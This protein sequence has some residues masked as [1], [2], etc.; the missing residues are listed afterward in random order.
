MRISQ[1]VTLLLFLAATLLCGCAGTGKQVVQ[2]PLLSDTGF[3]PV[4]VAPGDTL[5]SLADEHLGDSGK[6]WMLAEFNDIQHPEPGQ[7]LIVPL[8]PWSPGGLRPDGYQLVPILVYHHITPEACDKMSVPL[9]VFEAQMQLLRDE[10]YQVIPL[11]ELYKFMEM[12]SQIPKKSVV[13]TFDDGWRSFHDLAMPV[14]K[15]FGYPA[16]LFVYTDLIVGSRKTLSWDQVR[17]IAQA[18]FDIQCHSRTH[19]DLAKLLSG[20]DLP[21]YLNSLE[22]EIVTSSKIL[23]DKTGQTPRFM[24]YPYGTTNP[25]V[26]G[27]LRKHE[28]LGAFTVKRGGVPVFSDTLRIN[29]SMV[30]GDFTME[31]FREQLRV[32]QGEDIL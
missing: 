7:T 24:A 11:A 18:G 8:K 2:E 14:L 16:T 12:D 15:R 13:I 9:D 5:A 32:F 17:E 6:A 22:E 10:G 3:K 26:T 27:V 23:A 21:A 1:T 4:Q 19:R 20:E 25:L 29:R 31:Q 28:F 30:Y